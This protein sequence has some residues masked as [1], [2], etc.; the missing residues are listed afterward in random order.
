M[1]DLKTVTFPEQH[2]DSLSVVGKSIPRRGAPAN[3]RGEVKFVDDV[4]YRGM[5]H[6]K[7][8]RSPIHH[9]LIKSIDDSA[10]A[11]VDGFIRTLTH[12]DVPNNYFTPLQ[13]IGVSP[14]DEPVL[15]TDKVRHRGQSVIAVLGET[16]QA[17]AAA[18]AR[19]RVEYEELPA[20]FDVEQALEPTAPI[21]ATHGKNYWEY[22]GHPCRR[23]RFGDVA[24]GFEQA[25]VIV[26]DRYDT[27]PIEQAPL[28]TTACVAVPGSD[29]RVTVHTNTQALFF[30][31]ANTSII[32]DIA[33]HR[34]RF[35]GGV[36]GGG[37]GGKSDAITEP[38]AVVAANLTGRP[39]KF[40]YSREEEMQVSS[41]RA[42]WRFYIRDGVKRDGRIVAR[43]ITAYANCGAYTRLVN[44]GVTKCAA[45]LPGPYTIPNVS[46]D[47]YC[48][49]TNRQPGSAMR[50]FGCTMGD[51]AIE[52]Q[53][54]K[55]ATELNLDPWRV[56]MVNAYRDGDMKAHRKEV[57]G[58]AL[59]EVLQQAAQQVGH[60]L[61][62]DLASMRSF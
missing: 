58:A 29:G 12:H 38:L 5:L 31:L 9:G 32:S 57:E 41:T 51:F 61:S 37:F 40:K 21:V 13:I 26:E 28:E 56:R 55:I 15:A 2:D 45:H 36:V 54:D 16:P 20:V 30:T 6:L 33:P 11:E 22:E 48:V 23:V 35:L 60:E 53:M 19:V 34:L 59:I 7:M 18:A 4:A 49:Y 17:A 50:G 10:A 42:A 47:A 52:M 44:Y 14:N 43:E 62:A 24:A 3:V 1:Y 8:V 27:S 25:D 39:V 46:I